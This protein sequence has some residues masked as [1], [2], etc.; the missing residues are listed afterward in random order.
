M[1]NSAFF[2]ENYL[3][4]SQDVSGMYEIYLWRATRV[5]TRTHFL[6]SFCVQFVLSLHFDTSLTCPNALLVGKSIVVHLSGDVQRKFDIILGFS[7]S[8]PPQI[9]L[10][11]ASCLGMFHI[12]PASK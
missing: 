8:R 2:V 4:K 11:L 9:L 12:V 1:V 7:Y 3:I 6:L 10:L 5:I